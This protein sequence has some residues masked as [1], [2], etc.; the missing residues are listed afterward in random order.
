MDQ[1]EHG[2]LLEEIVVAAETRQR[3][4][5]ELQARGFDDVQP[6]LAPAVSRRDYFSAARKLL[7]PKA[8]GSPK[9]DGWTPVTASS[10]TGRWVSGDAG[11]TPRRAPGDWHGCML[12]HLLTCTCMCVRLW[13]FYPAKALGLR[14][15]LLV[16]SQRSCSPLLFKATRNAFTGPPMHCTVTLG[17][18]ACGQPGAARLHHNHILY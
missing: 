10:E 8:A 5:S 6:T 9:E 2:F 4:D 1:E 3:G 14:A 16:R 18:A 17:N 7:P 12:L 13:G 11:G 15:L